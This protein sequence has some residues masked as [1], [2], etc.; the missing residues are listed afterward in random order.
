MPSF[1]LSIKST[2]S[3]LE[4]TL[5]RF[6]RIFAAHSRSLFGLRHSLTAATRFKSQECTFTVPGRIAGWGCDLVM[7]VLPQ[8]NLGL[9]KLLLGS[10]L[11]LQCTLGMLGSKGFTFT[12]PGSTAGWSCS[13]KQKRSSPSVARQSLCSRGRLVIPHAQGPSSLRSSLIEEEGRCTYLLG[14]YVLF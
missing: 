14:H 9:D 3:R 8:T 13:C 4:Y 12:V 5:M 2:S 11:C 10:V 6:L 1:I 7:V